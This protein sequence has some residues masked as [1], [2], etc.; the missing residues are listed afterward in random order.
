MDRGQVSLIFFLVFFAATLVDVLTTAPYASDIALACFCFFIVLEITK[1]ARLNLIAAALLTGTGLIAGYVAGDTVGTLLKGAERTLPFLLLFGGV[2]CLRIPANVSPAL[3]GF[4]DTVVSQPA[5]R[6][7]FMATVSAHFLTIIFNLAGITLLSSLI[8]PGTEAGLQK[9]LG[10]ALSQGLAS[11]TCWAPF[12]VAVVVIYSVLPTVRWSVIAPYGLALSAILLS[13]S[14]FVDRV[15]VRPGT[16][17][18]TTAVKHPEYSQPLAGRTSINLLSIM[19]VLMAAFV[20][21][22]AGAGMTVPVAMAIIAPP[23]AFVWLRIIARNPRPD[24]PNIPN[25]KTILGEVPGLRNEATLFC[26]ANILAGG[27]GA[28]VAQESIGTRALSLVGDPFLLLAVLVVLHGA[29]NAM[30]VHPV[31]PAILIPTL[32][33]PDVIGIP[34]EIMALAM[35]AMWGQGAAV[36]PFSATAFVLARLSGCSNWTTSWGWN[37]RYILSSTPIIIAFL[38]GLFAMEAFA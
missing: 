23:F 4:R 28:A 10:R 15:F 33:P 21:A 11:A 18:A 34:P 14:W 17:S 13:W 20:I 36:S 27:I 5:G 24:T 3:L 6:R 1:V 16:P 8:R 30:G 2:L 38:Y 22:I 29:V 9:R 26:A 31:V 25:M 37:G 19:C 35:L 7:F 12:F 32:L